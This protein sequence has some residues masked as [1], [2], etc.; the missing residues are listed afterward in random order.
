[1]LTPRRLH[2]LNRILTPVVDLVFVITVVTA[3]FL[4][5]GWFY[6]VFIPFVERLAR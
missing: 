6:E 3:V 5:I 4:G 1:M 2:T